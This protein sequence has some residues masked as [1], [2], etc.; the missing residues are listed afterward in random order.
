MRRP[1]I[2]IVG[3]SRSGSTLLS[4]RLGSHSNIL[5]LP[6]THFFSSS[7]SGN[8][9]RRMMASRS[10]EAYFEYIYERNVRLLDIAISPE[11][12]KQQFIEQ[13]V[14]SPHKA[15]NVIFDHSLK[16]AN[17]NRILEK[18][19]RHIEY[20][21]MILRFYPDAKII[22][23]LRD[24]RDTIASLL[25]V[26]W[27]HSNANK[28]AAYWRWCVREAYSQQKKHGKNIEIVKFEDLVSDPNAVLKDLC[29]FIGESF[30]HKILSADSGATNVSEWEEDWKKASLGPI[31]K[32]N[33]YKWR[34]SDDQNQVY[35]WETIMLQEL[36]LLRYPLSNP[37]SRALERRRS[38]KIYSLAYYF[39]RIFR[40]HIAPRR[41]NFRRAQLKLKKNVD[42]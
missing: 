10:P 7:Y 33:I 8:F 42:G 11:E 32:S 20:I 12:L 36:E 39:H 13:N 40:T 23:I 9:V 17:K 24:G 5:S 1:P 31:D 38:L 4:S 37:I 21:S 18:T 34:N 26:D 22:C 35:R 30:E 16:S 27:T 3:P 14:I 29:D 6:E 25:K 41:N 2:F 19:P 28:H 15:L